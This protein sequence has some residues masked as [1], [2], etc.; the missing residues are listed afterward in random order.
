MAQMLLTISNDSSLVIDSLCD[1]A[2][3][4]DV[5]V[6]GLYCDFHTQHEQST[7]NMLGAML[8]QLASRGGIPNHTRKAF[9]E[10][11]EKFGGRG[12]LLPGMVD[13]FK[14]TTTSLSRLF[15]CID[16]L[17][18]SP[19][20]HRRELI[21][22]LREIVQASPGARVFLTGRPHID[23]EIVRCFSKVLRI[24]LSPTHRDI[25]SYL[26]MRLD[27]DAD[28]NAMDD[29]L[30]ADIMRIVPEKVSEM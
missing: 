29:E 3:G 4:K 20:K 18:E 11:K 23:D 12:L 13:I 5:A 16:A 7:T 21:E 15:I 24:P 28:P 14:K 19:S 30:R 26:E 2:E 8:K 9:R 1:Q 6:V 17:D 25:R 22:S 10:A 27:R